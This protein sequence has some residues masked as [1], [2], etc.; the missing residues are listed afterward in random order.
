MKPFEK[1]RLGRTDLHV[2]RLGWGGSGIGGLY[3]PSNEGEA[4]SVIGAALEMGINYFDTAPA[5]G[6]G[7]SEE[8][9]GKALDGRPRDSFVLSTKVSELVTAGGGNEEP[10]EFEVPRKRSFVADFGRDATV[11]SVEESLERLRLERID[12]LYIHDAYD[13]HTDLAIAEAYPVLDDLRAHGHIRAIGVGMDDCRIL[14]RFVRECD[15]DCILLWGRYSL[16]VQDAL[17]E[18]LP[19]CEER[20]VGI[21]LGAPYESGIL[22]SDLT[23]GAKF[24]YRDAPP[25]ILER[26]RAIDTVC[27]RHGVPLK[28][29][30]LQFPFGHPLVA[31]AIPGTRSAER[32][33]ENASM[34]EAAVPADLWSELKAEGHLP[35][36]APVPGN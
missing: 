25:E 28:A 8:R 4:V 22:A 36:G 2:T 24:R 18:L 20:G 33:L 9:L 26:A 17:D 21:V 10:D 35:D 5:Y 15:L 11:R 6:S 19:L 32:L 23:G 1:M 34:M 3:R 12:I 7:L 16:L 30:A 31:S 27:R 29:A 14:S 13:R